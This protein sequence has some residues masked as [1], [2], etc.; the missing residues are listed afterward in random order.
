MPGYANSTDHHVMKS[1][2][3]KG[4]PMNTNHN[5][6]SFWTAA[7]SASFAFAAGTMIAGTLGVLGPAAPASADSGKYVAVAVS[8]E[9]GPYGWGNDYSTENGAQQRSLT[10]CANHGGTHCVMAAWSHN[11]CVA[12]AVG[13]QD[14]YGGYKNYWGMNGATLGEAER[15]ALAKNGGGHVV[16]AKC[17]TGSEGIG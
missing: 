12:L 8:Q 3:P 9:K 5:A 7:A 15:A 13:D 14:A 2:D 6:S 10:E 1:D 16:V 11:G 17:S 4:N